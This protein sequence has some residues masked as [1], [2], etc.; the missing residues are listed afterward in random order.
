MR[1]DLRIR[2][3][4]PDTLVICIPPHAYLLPFRAFISATLNNIKIIKNTSVP[5]TESGSGE[6]TPRLTWLVYTL[7]A[8]LSTPQY[9]NNKEPTVKSVLYR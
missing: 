9:R 5:S 6:G 7:P 8:V 2:E 3:S 1:L 4:N